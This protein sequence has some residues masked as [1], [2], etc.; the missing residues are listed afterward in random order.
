MKRV[1]DV[2]R[3]Q[4]VNWPTVVGYPLGILASLPIL[5]LLIDITNGET[6][7]DHQIFILPTP[8]LMIVTAHLQTMTQ[9]FPFALGLSVTRRA[10]YAATALVVTA[11]AALFGLLMLAF[12][13]IERMTGGWGRHI[14]IFGL[15]PL[16]Q[17]NPVTQ[18]LA[19]TVPL[20]VV[21]AIAV[22]V[23]VVFQRWR[24]TG[25]YVAGLGGAALFTGVGVLVTKQ[26]WWPAV[27]RFF[28]GQPTLALVAGYPLLIALLIGGVGWLAIR[29]ATP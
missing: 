12:D 15:G 13:G 22:L 25:I 8:Y 19:Y 10:F 17:D 16:R 26:G 9:M 21:S 2:S 7:T 6:T 29:R 11:Q 4:L 24:Q 28:A 3:I 18:W 5:G 27:G 20:M 14:Q 1:L 23:G